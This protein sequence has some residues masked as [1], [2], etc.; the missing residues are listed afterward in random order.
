MY[1]GVRRWCANSSKVRVKRSGKGTGEQGMALEIRAAVKVLIKPICCW[2]VG[3][4]INVRGLRGC[5]CGGERL[6]VPAEPSAP[7]SEEL[8]ISSLLH[9]NFISRIVLLYSTLSFFCFDNIGSAAYS[10]LLVWYKSSLANILR[11][12]NEDVSEPLLPRKR[13][14]CND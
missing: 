9:L 4:V 7:V 6:P 1:L 12:H 13:Q 2:S 11:A 8:R 3:S 10:K 14:M 5:S